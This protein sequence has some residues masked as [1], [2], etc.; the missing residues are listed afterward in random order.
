[1][2]QQR[3]KIA[4]IFSEGRSLAVFHHW[5]TD[6]IASAAL[7]LRKYE[8]QVA[9]VMTPR[10]GFYSEEAVDVA[11]VPKD[12]NYVVFLDYGVSGEIYD[13]ISRKLN[14]PLIVIDH[15]FTEPWNNG[16]SSVYYNPVAL[17]VGSEA[18]YPSTTYVLSKILDVNDER[19]IALVALGIIGDLTPYLDSGTDHQ[20]LKL[21]RKLIVNMGDVKT[22]R[23]AVDVIDSCYRIADNTC[24]EHAVRKLAFEDIEAVVNDH[25]LIS[26]YNSSREMMVK[27]LSAL[28]KIFSN[29]EFAVYHLRMDAYV[30]SSVGRKLAEENPSKIIILVHE[31][32]KI[33]GG[34]IY[35]RSMRESLKK[36]IKVLRGKGLK[37][38]GKETVVVAEFKESYEG[39]LHKI[40]DGV[41]EV[42][43]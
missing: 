43:G 33:G 15:H 19:D 5:D 39:I 21:L 14:K 3:Q 31:I 7:I 9:A 27:A 18:E 37:I 28:D 40:I 20:G 1:M 16:V 13:R 24:V 29:T 30:T 17:G 25:Q 12:V 42:H 11:F 2:I 6:G 4:K 41:K 22:L 32:P 34:F 26:A 38:G 35:V 36:L 23:R 10:I 8:G